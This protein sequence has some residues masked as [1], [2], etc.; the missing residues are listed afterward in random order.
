MAQC[1]R[2]TAA[3]AIARNGSALLRGDRAENLPLTALVMACKARA[4]SH[5]GSKR[6]GIIQNHPAVNTSFESNEL[7]GLARD[8]HSRTHSLIKLAVSIANPAQCENKADNK[9]TSSGIYAVAV[10]STTSSS[11]RRKEADIESMSWSSV[12]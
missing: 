10:Q 4:G 6:V 3:E 12:C 5:I 1:Q 8:V 11:H 2:A 7:S 9:T